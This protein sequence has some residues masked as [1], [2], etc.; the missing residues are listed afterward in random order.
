MAESLKGARSTSIDPLVEL[1]ETL[2]GKKW[3]P[4]G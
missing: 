2:R 1:I 4:L 3:M